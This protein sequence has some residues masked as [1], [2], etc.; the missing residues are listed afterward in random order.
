MY[1]KARIFIFIRNKI[2]KTEEKGVGMLVQNGGR[3]GFL[4]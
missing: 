2:L 1:T 4:I 3:T